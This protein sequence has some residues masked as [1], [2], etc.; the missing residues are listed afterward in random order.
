M[1]MKL[2][3]IQVLSDF[4][5]EFSHYRLKVFLNADVLINAG[6]VA[7]ARSLKKI[8]TYS[9]ACACHSS[10]AK[11]SEDCLRQ[12]TDLRDGLRRLRRTLKVIL[13]L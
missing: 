6:D 2:I 4:H 13:R 8:Q 12:Q 9:N 1:R 10:T 5:T 11:S 3:R 7:I